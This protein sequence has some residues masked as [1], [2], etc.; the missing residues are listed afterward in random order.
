MFAALHGHSSVLQQEA[1]LGPPS[2]PGGPAGSHSSASLTLGTPSR[3]QGGATSAL[4]RGASGSVALRGGWE[5]GVWGRHGV[6]TGLGAPS[7]RC[8][9]GR[10]PAGEQDT[11]GRR[12]S[13]L[14]QAQ[15]WEICSS[16]PQHPGWGVWDQ[17]S[18]GF[19]PPLTCGV[20]PNP[21]ILTCVRQPVGWPTAH[22]AGSP[23]CCLALIFP[24]H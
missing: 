20:S 4:R 2:H 21:V 19:Q 3:F 17:D 7:T 22:L 9:G 23:K 11:W 10:R 13:K 12:T 5:Q 1:P 8:Q 16:G 18:W 15:G 24:A 14:G 6:V